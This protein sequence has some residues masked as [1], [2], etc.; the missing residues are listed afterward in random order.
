MRL[1]VALQ[2]RLKG[3]AGASLVEYAFLVLLI[4]IV[5]IVVVTALGESTSTSFSN[6]NDGLVSVNN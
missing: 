5:A 4:A 2:T 1:I 3:D 6:M